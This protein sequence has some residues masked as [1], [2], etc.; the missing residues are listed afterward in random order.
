MSVPPYDYL[1]SDMTLRDY[2]AAA[3]LQSL[4]IRR[5]EKEDEDD[6][7]VQCVDP[8]YAADLAY[9]YADAMLARRSDY[10]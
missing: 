5:A 4:N 6:Y 7:D 3:A 8:D 9:T 2:F 1:A 10:E